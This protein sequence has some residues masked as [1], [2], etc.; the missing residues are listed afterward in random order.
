MTTNSIVEQV[1]GLKNEGNL[2]FAAKDYKLSVQKFTEAITIDPTNG[3]FFSNRSAAFACLQ[4]WEDALNDA[5]KAIELKPDWVKGYG[6]KG[7]ALQGLARWEEALQAFQD[8]LQLEPENA[9]LIKGRDACQAKLAES[10]GSS[11]NDPSSM[12]MNI[13]KDPKFFEKISKNPQTAPLLADP[14]FVN[15]VNS[16]LHNPS[17]LMSSLQ[18]DPRLLQAMLFAMGIQTTSSEET[19]N[20][21][22]QPEVKEKPV[23]PEKKEEPKIDP[24]VAEAQREKELGNEAYKAKDFV[25]AMLHYQRAAELEPSNISYVLNQS[26][27]LFEQ[28]LYQDCIKKCEEAIS[29]GREQHADFKQIAKAFSRIASCHQRLGDI[30][31]AIKF[32]NKSLTEHR[33]PDTLEKLRSLEREKENLAKLALHDPVKAEEARNAGNE[34]FKQG[35]YADAVR[36][37]T[38]AIKRDEKDPRA[39]SNRAACYTKLAAVPE[40]LKDCET[41]IKLDPSFV[42]AYIRKASLLL[43]KREYSEAMQVCDVAESKDVERKH[44]KEIM[45][46]KMKA[47]MEQYGSTAN[48]TEDE[49]R[50]RAMRNPE[51]V[52]ILSD[53]AM[54]AVL[55]QMSSDPRAAAEHL[56]NPMVAG[57]IRKLMDAGII[58]TA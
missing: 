21:A 1:E 47:R 52:Q 55:Q 50:E 37:Y 33:T 49:V 39:Y 31:G 25:N 24:I 46:L 40:G 9:Q 13:L 35:K 4:R 30:D 53:P 23:E 57:K 56:K 8:G 20:N 19:S 51:V 3:V 54:Q 16:I 42:K 41:A 2:A 12:F 17:L 43:M 44:S 48:M 58:R 6:R 29:I 27:V 32:Y 15:L 34:L 10:S 38:E 11:G 28:S 7:T 14:S 22:F 5:E 36:E 26:A 45:E 18:S